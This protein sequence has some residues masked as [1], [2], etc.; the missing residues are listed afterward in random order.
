MSFLLDTNVISEL[1]KGARGNADVMRWFSGVEDE[2]LYTSVIVLGELRYG[3]ERARRRDPRQAE[4]L[5]RW[6]DRVAR[7]FAD[8]A[9]PVDRRV[10]DEWGRLN[11]PDPL[12]TADALLAATAKVHRL[13]LVTR[14]VRDIARTGVS[15]LNPFDPAP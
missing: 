1:R 10:A 7:R 13:T 11:V 8:R 3:V 5:E 2:E 15:Y 6:L 12:P 9:L 14:D 4:A